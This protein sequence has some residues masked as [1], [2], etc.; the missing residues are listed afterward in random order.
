MLKTALATARK[1]GSVLLRDAVGVTGCGSIAYGA[2]LAWH[3]A[4]F[5]VAGGF[6][7]AGAL[8]S[9]RAR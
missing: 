9:A 3:P 6:A 8:L 2:W 5:V 4:G 7:V 1:N